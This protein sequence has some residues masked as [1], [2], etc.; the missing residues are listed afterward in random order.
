MVMCPLGGVTMIT[1]LPNIIGHNTR[2]QQYLIEIGFFTCFYFMDQGDFMN[3]CQVVIRKEQFQY[4]EFNDSFPPKYFFCCLT[5]FPFSNTNK[6]ANNNKSLL[7][8]KYL[9][10][11]LEP[12]K[13]KLGPLKWFLWLIP[14]PNILPHYSIPL[15]CSHH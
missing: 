12:S 4:L 1:R 13:L 9:K 5:S 8:G 6:N 2:S 10:A 11:N 7:L 14:L 15:N 3:L